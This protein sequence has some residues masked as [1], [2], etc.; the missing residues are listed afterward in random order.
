MATAE[1]EGE[2]VA[3]RIIRITDIAEEPLGFLVPISGYGKMPLVS[4]EDAVQ[5][6]VSILPEV[7]SHAYVAKQRCK[8]PADELTQDES[9]SIMLYT[10]GWEPLDECLYVALNQT[11]R[12]PERQQKLKPWYL[13]LRLFLNALFRLPLLHKIAYRGVKLDM[14]KKYIQGETVVWWGFSSCTVVLDVLQSKLFLGKTGPRTIFNIEC[15]SARDIRK[16]SYYPTEDEVLLLAGTQFTVTGCLDQGSLH[17]IHLKE[18]QAPHP[19]LQPVSVVA[20]QSNN[21]SIAVDNSNEIHSKTSLT[22]SKKGNSNSNIQSNEGPNINGSKKSTRQRHS[23]DPIHADTSWLNPQYHENIESGGTSKLSKGQDNNASH[24]PQ[25]I[26]MNND[27]GGTRK[28]RP[29]HHPS[30][31]LESHELQCLFEILGNN[32]VTLATAV[33]QIFHGYNGTWR[34]QACGVLCFV[35]DYD[36]R[37]YHFR[38]YDL[39]SKQAIYEEV[40]PVIL[41]LEKA[42]D[43]FY[44]FDGSYCKIGINFVDHDEAQTFS[45]DFDSKQGHRQKKKKTNATTKVT[46]PNIQP[47]VS[48]PGLDVD[49]IYTPTFYPTFNTPQKSR[50]RKKSKFFNT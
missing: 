32:R 47:L 29:T 26:T 12:S 1:A 16:H 9:A 4:L 36:N 40:V 17:I 18:T 37:N 2:A 49:H 11:L 15:E 45:H 8:T 30:K 23:F 13:Y 42:T 21:L 22:S 38:L 20:P 27:E 24:H 34:K 28:Q 33:V 46:P 35:K 6:L 10:M 48:S 14:K 3:Q 19:L 7:Q 39:K 50:H 31:N 44:T 25:S 41:R 43:V 5:P